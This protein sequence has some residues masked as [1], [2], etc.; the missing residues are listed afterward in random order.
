MVVALSHLVMDNGANSNNNPLCNKAI[1]ITYNG[2]TQVAKVVDTCEGC[3]IG[4]IDMSPSLF[5]KFAPASAGRVNGVVWSV[6]S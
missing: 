2:V 6:A 5:A 1:T 4:D 3:A